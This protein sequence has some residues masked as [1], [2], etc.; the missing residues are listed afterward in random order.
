MKLPD[1]VLSL[2]LLNSCHH[3]SLGIHQFLQNFTNAH[4][5]PFKSSYSFFLF[6][7]KNLFPSLILGYIRDQPCLCVY[8]G[9]NV[10]FSFHLISFILGDSSLFILTLMLEFKTC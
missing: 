10:T 1:K 6:S 5:F 7:N 4:K 3:T 9:C 8:P 2:S